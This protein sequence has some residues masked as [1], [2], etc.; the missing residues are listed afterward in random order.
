MEK[1][2]HQMV[3]WSRSPLDTTLVVYGERLEFSLSER[4]KQIVEELSL[5][6]QKRPHERNACGQDTDHLAANG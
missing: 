2:D 4:Q 5:E 3:A 6:E 1:R